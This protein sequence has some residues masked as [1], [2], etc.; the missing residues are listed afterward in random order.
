MAVATCGPSPIA[1]AVTAKVC[2]VRGPGQNGTGVFAARV[3]TATPPTEMPFA[4][5]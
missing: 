5:E 1:K 2:K 4:P 3:I